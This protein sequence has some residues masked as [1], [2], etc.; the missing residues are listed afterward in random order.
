M[1]WWRDHDLTVGGEER[2]ANRRWYNTVRYSQERLN[3][4]VCDDAPDCSSGLALKE[5]RNGSKVVTREARIAFPVSA[6]L[7][8]GR[9]T[10]PLRVYS[11]IAVVRRCSLSSATKSAA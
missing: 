7:N 6:D 8:D 9:P 4:T 5:A 1:I 2:K 10:S 11:R 3:R